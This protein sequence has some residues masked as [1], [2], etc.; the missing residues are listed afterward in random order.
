[1]ALKTMET[2]LQLTLGPLL[3]HW[4]AAHKRDFYARIADEAPI[5]V[6]Y[7]GEVVCS[8]RAP[9]FDA[10][11]PAVV[12]R[13]VRGGKQVVFSSLAEVVLRRE[14]Q[15][16]ASLSEISE[17]DVEANDVSALTCLSGRPH[18][19]GQYLNVYNEETLRHLAERG[20]H[21]FA[22]PAELPREGVAALSAAAQDLDVGLEI[23]VFGKA[24]LALSARCYHARAHGRT[25]DNCQFVCE[26]DADGMPLRT[27]DGKSWLSVNGVQTLSHTHLCLLGEIEELRNVGVTHLRL[28]PHSLDMLAVAQTF[29]DVMD[30]GLE[31]GAG[32]ERLMAMDGVTALANGFWHGAA[33]HRFVAL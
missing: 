19:I 9:L 1:M 28:S 29:R 8:K 4:P 16:T 24:P 5:D 3:F 22:L 12:E 13:L 7:L 18:R 32:Q 21:H 31:P 27:L 17:F 33:G 26:E 25:K 20:A 11:Y 23:Q 30:G 14:R 15:M 10:H 2:S 6:V